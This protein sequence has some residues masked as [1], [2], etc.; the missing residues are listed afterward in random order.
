MIHACTSTWTQGNSNSG[1]LDELCFWRDQL[2]ENQGRCV[3]YLT[4][5]QPSTWKLWRGPTFKASS[6]LSFTWPCSVVYSDSSLLRA[7]LKKMTERKSSSN[8]PFLSYLVPIH[9]QRI[10]SRHMVDL[11]EVHETYSQWNSC[12]FKI[13][14]ITKDFHDVWPPPSMI[15]KKN[16]R[17]NNLTENKNKKRKS[18]LF[19]FLLEIRFKRGLWSN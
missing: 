19:S 5:L 11:K 15:P 16:H 8:I 9:F 14:Q 1:V 12:S 18:L 7:L 17:R 13:G 2:H 10:F 6:T 3:R 4:L